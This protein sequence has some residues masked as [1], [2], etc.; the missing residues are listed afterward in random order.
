MT[1]LRYSIFYRND[2]KTY[3]DVWYGDFSGNYRR[4]FRLN[5][6]PEILAK[7]E[8]YFYHDPCCVRFTF[9]INRQYD[10]VLTVDNP[11]IYKGF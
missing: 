2:S 3:I 6:S 1:I 5:Y 4:K 8:I 9:A 7:I 10:H 11:I